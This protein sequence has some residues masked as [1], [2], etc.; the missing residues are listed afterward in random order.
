[1]GIAA[2]AIATMPLCAADKPAAEKAD[3]KAK[4]EAPGKTENANRA[5]P[6]KGTL[7]AKSATSITVGTRTFELTSETKIMKDG[8]AATLADGEVGK[9][10]AGSYREDGGKLTAKSV[11]FGPKPPEST[12]KKDKPAKKADKAEKPAK[13]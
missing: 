4:K 12:D 2:L 8:K 6:F 5:I 7:D 11:R 3:G 13:Q 10:V 1:M 9:E